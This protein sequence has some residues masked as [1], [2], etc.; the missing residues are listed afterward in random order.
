MYHP[1]P[2]VAVSQ[3]LL[4]VFQG[5]EQ[6]VLDELQQA[7]AGQVGC[8]DRLRV[9]ADRA[10]VLPGPEGPVAVA[11]NAPPVRLLAMERALLADRFKLKVHEEMRQLGVFDLVRSRADGR[12]G[13]RLV[14]SDGT[15]LP[16]PSTPAP[17]ADFT[18]YCGV[19]R[20]TRGAM[21]AKGLPLSRF[22]LL[23]SFVPDVQRIVRD[24]T[25]LE[26]AFDLD[27]EFAPAGGADAPDLPPITT[28]LK[29]QLGLELRPA[30]GSVSV[31][32]IDSVEPP[33]P[34]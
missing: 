18:P 26:G 28:A 19:K 4:R 30:T 1:G 31:I 15:C 27:I 11:P 29:E 12:L 8:R 13:P 21:S 6:L 10:V 9:I 23:L 5:R 24:R 7:V 20:S 22:A 17:I 32:V 14:R 33:T 25:G 3:H 34:D 16:L 2:P